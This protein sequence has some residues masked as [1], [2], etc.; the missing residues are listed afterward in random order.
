MA[1][2]PTQTGERSRVFGRFSIVGTLRLLL[3]LLISAPIFVVAKSVFGFENELWSLLWRTTLV[4]QVITTVVL[5]VT[6]S[7]AATL[8]GAAL[9]WLVTA[10]SF[11]GSTVFRRMLMLPF[12]IP[13][14]VL[15]FLAL[16]LFDFTGPVQTAWRSTFG[17]EA[18]FPNVR[19]P[20]TAWLVMSLAFM[21]YAYIASMAA[22]SER[23]AAP[24]A[25]ARTLGL[26]PIATWWRVVLPMARPQLGAAGALILMETVTDVGVARTFGIRT[27]AD[28]MIRA[29][30][31]LDQREGAAELAV[32]LACTAFGLIGLERL[33]R[34]G[35]FRERRIR[36]TP[37]PAVPLTGRSRW[38]AA[39][40]CLFVS[41]LS[42]V[43][44]VATLLVW[45]IRATRRGGEGAFDSRFWSLAQTSVT[46][47][48]LVGTVCVLVVC[49]LSLGRSTQRIEKRSATIT[50]RLAWLASLGYAMPGLVVAVGTLQIL[51]SVDGLL[52]RLAGWNEHLYLSFLVA[53]SFGGVVYGLTIRF[54][55]VGRENVRAGIDRL[56]PK[57][58]QAARSLGAGSARLVFR[59]QLPLLRGSL[60]VAALLV[61]LDTLKELPATLLLRPPGRDTLAVFV[62]N[63]TNESRWEEAAAP[64]LAIVAIGVPL[65]WAAER[66]LLRST[67]NPQ[68]VPS[69]RA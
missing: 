7:L 19:T 26:G 25:A 9:G 50:E 58:L 59:I 39:G 20:F 6:V 2:I 45:S 65:V 11:P 10:Y 30:F 36:S 61:A 40:V 8:S 67:V 17:Q 27:L 42:F 5:G 3:L 18:W 29:W 35:S 31:G 41:S 55:G 49:A 48:A 63:M 37:I 51:S 54:L 28:G 57:M 64:A 4:R 24:S 22:Y 16:G 44:P 38:L 15:A 13:A 46:L 12:A 34:R 33:T 14:Y 60:I 66:L 56:N 62:W 43:G 32:L 21:P 23:G 68:Q 1:L 47:A 52:D 69:P 53:G